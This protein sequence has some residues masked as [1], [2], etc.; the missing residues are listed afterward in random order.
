MAEL[1]RKKIHADIAS[2]MQKWW[3]WN[4]AEL[5][6]RARTVSDDTLIWEIPKP[7]SQKTLKDWIYALN[8]E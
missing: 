5:Q 8:A 1:T 4:E 7:I 6:K 2:E 3:D